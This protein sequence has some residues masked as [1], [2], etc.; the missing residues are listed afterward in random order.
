MKTRLLASSMLMTA[1]MAFTGI[2]VA[3]DKPITI[4]AAIAQTG[5]IAAYDAD[6]AKAAEMA[7]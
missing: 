2:A 6:P 7:V 3:E 5:F 4:G 1:M